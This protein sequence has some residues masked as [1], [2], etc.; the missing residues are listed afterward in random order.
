MSQTLISN[1]PAQSIGQVAEVFT[2]STPPT[3]DRSLYGSEFPFFGPSDFGSGK[4]L[5]R[6]EKNLSMKG[7][8]ASR[9]IPE[10]AILFTCIGIIGKVGIAT[11]NSS[12][13][14]QINYVIPFSGIDNEYLYYALQFVSPIIRDNATTQV[15][16]MINKS[17]FEKF[18]IP[19]PDYK[20]QKAIALALS[21]I[22]ELIEA[23][24]AEISK[25]ENVLTSVIQR[26]LPSNYLRNR[27]PS[28]WQ[29][30]TLGELGTISGAGVDK[31][32][33]TLDSPIKLVNYMDVYKNTFI[34]PSSNFMD[35]T[36][37]RDQIIHCSLLAGDVLFTPTSETPED[38]A[39]S[40]V[41]SIDLRDTC[42]SYH[43]IRF[44]PKVELDLNYL[45]YV[46]LL[47]DF[48]QQAQKAAE[49]SGTRYVITLPRFRSLLI[50]V[51]N[52]ATQLEIGRKIHDIAKR[53][54]ILRFELKKYQDIKQ[55]MAHDL[56]TGKVR[57]V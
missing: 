20:E 38:I 28:G 18:E 33:R 36:A 22:D 4:F 39:R 56:L 16:P 50:P 47:E 5:Y 34:T 51:P 21:D 12:C 41:V 45:A 19:I 32:I 48:R 7:F 9:K 40:A 55:G 11:R 30:R 29:L 8:S 3:S 53:I 23:Y 35:T 24:Q 6:A 37:N 27:L 25:N 13:N 49:G 26:I 10:N 57:L 17:E 14:Q 42:Y 52:L 2:G 46:F 54:E 31:V 43:L 1:F 15:V 44:R